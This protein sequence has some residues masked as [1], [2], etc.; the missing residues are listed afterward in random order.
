MQRL[1]IKTLMM[2]W[3]SFS[4]SVGQGKETEFEFGI[5]S[6]MVR[7]KVKRKSI[8]V[9]MHKSFNSKMVRLKGTSKA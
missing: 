6:K 1:S 5:N 4:K 2:L 7:L 3:M 8:D 9:V